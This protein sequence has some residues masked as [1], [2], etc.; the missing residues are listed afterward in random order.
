MPAKRAQVILLLALFAVA[1]GL[2]TLARWVTERLVPLQRTSTEKS[3][4][5]SER[6]AGP[7][8][9]RPTD[10]PGKNANLKKGTG[11]HNEP[12]QPVFPLPGMYGRLLLDL[13]LFYLILG[14]VAFITLRIRR[15]QWRSREEHE[16]SSSLEHLLAG[17]AHEVR[18]P[19]NTISLKSQYLG[20]L[21]EDQ[22]LEKKE[23]IEQSLGVVR[24][25]IARLESMIQAFVRY[26]RK[27]QLQFRRIRLD[28]IL[29]DVLFTLA[30]PLQSK[31]IRVEKEIQRGVECPLDRKHLKDVFQGL[32]AKSIEAT[33]PEG[34]IQVSL[35]KKKNAAILKLT[36]FGDP[37]PGE[38][39]LHIF[40]PYFA[41]GQRSF[42]LA[43]AQT[44]K[45]VHILDGTITVSSA[46]GEGTTFTM[47]IPLRNPRCP[48]LEGQ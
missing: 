25:E 28:E 46:E 22:P 13:L 35:A 45:I 10:G 48:S 7:S 24:G 34:T 43:L 26:G 8:D 40:D 2:F 19:L 30:E 17:V 11:T 18:N 39:R 6:E 15:R 5:P 20:K 3:L 41:T 36:D 33:E 21:L 29:E 44:K 38:E 12:R 9:R 14:T 32:L 42:G 23:S 37:I 31:G 47:R 16:F 1:G 4:N 27:P